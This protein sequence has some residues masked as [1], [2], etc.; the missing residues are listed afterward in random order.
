MIPGVKI[1][2][3]GKVRDVY[4]LADKLLLVTSN[5]ISAYDYVMSREIPCKGKVLNGI[6]KYWFEKTKHIIDNHLITAKVEEYPEPVNTYRKSLTGN[7]MLTEKTEAIPIEC[8]VRGYLA[9]SA[10]LEY[11]EKGT[12][13]GIKVR[14]GMQEFEKLD[15]PLFTPA[16]KAESG[17]DEN[18]SFEKMIEITGEKTASY[19]KEKSIELYK[20]GAAHLEEKGII[21]A[22]TKFE[23]GKN[24]DGK[25]I[26]IDEVL[27]PDS[28]R[29][30]IA[31][32]YMPGV[33]QE[34]F[35]KQVLRDY[36]TGISWDKKPPIPELPDEVIEFTKQKYLQVY[37]MITG[38]KPDC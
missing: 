11:K 8:V 13:C 10:W 36:L 3:Q 21:L 4:D 19:L 15:E 12:V 30:W 37:E 6:A 20:F 5:R 7:S 35:D 33:K 16:T 9:G 32:S 23:F 31:E 25:L 34:Q 2:K 14:N 24:N 26:L 22:D 27:T 28:S 1:F 38:N 29:F 18:I 17:H